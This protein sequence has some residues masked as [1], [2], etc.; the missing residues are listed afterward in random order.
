VPGEANLAE[1][2]EHAAA[3]EARAADRLHTLDA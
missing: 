2:L 3:G 1:L